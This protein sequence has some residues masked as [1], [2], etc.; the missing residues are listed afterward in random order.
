MK[1][2]AE[3]HPLI[4]CSTFCIAC[5]LFLNFFRNVQNATKSAIPQCMIYGNILID[6]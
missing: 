5:T 3:H 4:A 2:M 6:Y 1:V